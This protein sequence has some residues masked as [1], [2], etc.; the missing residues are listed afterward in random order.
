MKDF[1]KEFWES[2]A[3]KHKGLHTASWGDTHALKL[4]FDLISEYIKK[5]LKV[6]DVG[7]SNGFATIGQA[8]EKDID[9]VGMDYSKEMIRYANENRNIENI[10]NL[11]FI[12]GDIT[13]IPLN[14]QQFDLVY[15]TRVLINLPTWKQQIT[16]IEECLRVVKDGGIV[17]FSEGFYEPFVK[18]NSLR[19]MVGLPPLVEHD[20]NRYIKQ[21]YLEKYLN[22]KGYKYKIIDYT[23]VYY[24]G[25]RFLREL[26]TDSKSF[27]GFSNPINLD[28]YKLEKKYSGGDFGI[29]KAI[30]VYK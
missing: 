15:T 3:K 11:S 28:F 2:Q 12:V 6:L 16:G 14:D 24:L 22:S 20:Y 13:N 1:I 18:L 10:R 21:S 9:I 7:C 19:M 29:Q 17:L 5:G 26:V 8:K 23:S 27:E 25:S 4:E 30:I